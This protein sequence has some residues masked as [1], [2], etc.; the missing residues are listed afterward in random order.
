MQTPAPTPKLLRQTLGAWVLGI[1]MVMGPLGFWGTQISN[2]LDKAK[3]E[4]M[5]TTR[6]YPPSPK[7]H[8]S[9]LP[10]QTRRPRGMGAC[11]WFC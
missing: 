2:P 11:L 4:R 9:S 3:A 8:K 6:V 5:C 10:H 1:S 7:R